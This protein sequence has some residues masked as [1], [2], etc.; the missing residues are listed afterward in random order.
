MIIA[1]CLFFQSCRKVDIILVG[2]L[3]EKYLGACPSGSS[4]ALNNDN[5]TIVGT[6]NRRYDPI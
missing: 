4:G 2:P 6:K 1:T 3:P 5:L